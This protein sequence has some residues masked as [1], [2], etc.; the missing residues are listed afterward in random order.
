MNHL[1]SEF[2]HLSTCVDSWNVL[3]EDL[4]RLKEMVNLPELESQI[5]IPMGKYAFTPG[6]VVQ[7]PSKEFTVCLGAGIFVKM[8]REET[9]AFL[10]QKT[11]F[12]EQLISEATMKMNEISA[13]LSSI[14]SSGGSV[15]ACGDGIFEVQE[16]IDPNSEVQP[17]RKISTVSE[18]Q[19][20]QA[21][22]KLVHAE[23][24][25]MELSESQKKDMEMLEELVRALE[26][27]EQA[28]ELER[29]AKALK[30]VEREYAL[31]KDQG[32]TKNSAEKDQEKAKN[33]VEKDQENLARSIQIE[34][35]THSVNNELATH[36]LQN[37]HAT[38]SINNEHATHSVNNEHATH[39]L[40]KH[41]ATNLPQSQRDQQRKVTFNHSV[42]VL[43]EN[44]QIAEEPLKDFDKVQPSNAHQTQKSPLSLVVK[45]RVRTT[46]RSPTL[47]ESNILMK[48]VKSE[49]TSMKNRRTTRESTKEFY[50]SNA[51]QITSESPAPPHGQSRFR[52]QS[53]TDQNTESE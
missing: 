48:E 18:T 51:H 10:H 53:E 32:K 27:E 28:E 36:S 33:S 2:L 47:D 17:A 9:T 49:Y 19:R 13:C 5:M 11:L 41:S 40:H 22:E 4:H 6:T 43:T 30:Q 15:T 8:T 42:S 29:Q 37:E 3:L 12:F 45:E 20:M 44:K 1:E 39:S 50:S 26:I 23:K 38:H 14:Q 35:A 52:S 31:E 34:H 24:A 25:P 16:K 46:A 21:N 7:K